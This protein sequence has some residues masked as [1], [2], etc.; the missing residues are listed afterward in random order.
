M[1]RTDS[2][3]KTLML[4]GIG[5]RRRR[6]QQRIDGITDSM[7]MSLSNLRELVMDREAWRA[8][9]HEV[10]KSRTRLS[11]WTELKQVR[12]IC[13]ICEGF[14]GGANGKES[15]CQ[16]RR[17]KRHQFNLWVGNI[18]WRKAWQ[19]T[20]ILAWKIPW[21]EEPG[22]WKFSGLQE[23]RQPYGGN[24]HHDHLQILHTAVFPNV[25]LCCLGKLPVLAFSCLPPQRG[26]RGPCS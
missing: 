20:S 23:C 6:G 1:W 21:T 22:G 2:L 15:A 26:V 19:P 17:N 3:E 14:P 24:H 4:G 5:G 10:A 9:V 8:A 25:V 16:C 18:S 12:D 13:S 7:D 11:N